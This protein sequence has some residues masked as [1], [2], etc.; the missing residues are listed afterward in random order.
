MLTDTRKKKILEQDQDVFWDPY[1]KN[2]IQRFMLS[3]V[4]R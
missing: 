3:E 4:D 2:Q 1:T